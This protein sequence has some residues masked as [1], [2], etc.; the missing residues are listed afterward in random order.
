MCA[1]WTF[2]SRPQALAK[3]TDAKGPMQPRGP[4]PALSR[5]EKNIEN[6]HPMMHMT[7]SKK[8]Y[9]GIEWLGICF[10]WYPNIYNY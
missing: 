9:M 3:Y 6:V 10:G 8:T 2:R 4:L 7:A 1:T 5:V